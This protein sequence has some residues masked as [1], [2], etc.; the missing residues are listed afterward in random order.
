[1]VNKQREKNT[2]YISKLHEEEIPDGT[3]KARKKEIENYNK[4]LREY[5]DKELPPVYEPLLLN[6]ELLFDLIQIDDLGVSDKDKEKINRILHQ[7]NEQ[8]FLVD[9][10]DSEYWIQV[11]EDENASNLK[12]QSFEAD[13]D[14]RKLSI[15]VFLVTDDAKIT[16]TTSDGTVFDDWTIEKVDRVNEN[17][18]SSFVVQYVSKAAE[19]HEYQVGDEVQVEIVPKDDMSLRKYRFTFEAIDSFKSA[20]PI[21]PFNLFDYVVSAH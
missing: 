20:L 2:E 11:G 16:V 9:V 15:P 7:N 17:D 10:L 4:A 21:P 5:R 3:D 18:L 1:M 13:F 8:I 12:H 6:C 19:T 14:G